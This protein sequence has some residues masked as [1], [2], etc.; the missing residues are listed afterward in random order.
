MD[1]I[2]K[3][4]GRTILFVSHN[5]ETVRRLCNKAVYLRQ[6]RLQSI[7]PIDDVCR[8]YEDSAS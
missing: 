5:M 6:G 7:G 4:Q 3:N 2:S 8:E 1:D